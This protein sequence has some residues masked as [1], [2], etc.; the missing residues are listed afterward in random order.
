MALN[1][2]RTTMKLATPL[3]IGTCIQFD[4][5]PWTV[6]GFSGSCVQCRNHQGRT[7]IHDI[8]FLTV[9]EGFKVLNGEELPGPNELVTFP[10]NV[11]EASLRQAETILAHLNEAESGYKSGNRET[12]L[13]EEPRPEYDPEYSTLNQRMEAKSR[14]TGISV[15][16]LWE[17]KA[18]YKHSGI[19]G[20]IDKRQLKSGRNNITDHRVVAAL[21]QVLKEHRDK[22]N[23]TDKRLIALTEQR[24]QDLYPGEKIRFPSSQTMYRILAREHR[25]RAPKSAKRRRNDAN[26]PRT[27]YRHQVSTRPGEFVLIDSTPFDAFALDPV[28]FKWIQLQLTIAIDLFSRSIVGWRFTPVS[29]KAVDAA[30]LLYDIIRPKLM[31]P[32]W[33]QNARWAYLGVPETVVVKL[34]DDEPEDGIAGVPLLH[35]ETIVVDHGKAFISR[36]FKDACSRLGINVQLARTYTPTDKAQVERTFRTIREDFIEA[37]PGY[38]GPDLY[39]RGVNIEDDAF[40]FVDEIDTRFSAWVACE[41]QRRPHEGLFLP[42]VPLLEVSSNEM[43]E[44]GIARAG[45]VYVVASELMYYE[46][47]P[48]EWRTVQHYGVELRGLRYNADILNDYHNVESPWG[49]IHAGKWPIRYDPRDLS[50]VFFFD[51]YSSQWRELPWTHDHGEGRPFNEA[52]LSYAK[53]LLIRRGGNPSDVDELAEAMNGLLDRMCTPSKNDRRERRLAAIN[54]IHS[55][56]V[57]RDQP[58]VKGTKVAPDDEVL[59]VSDGPIEG[60]RN[61]FMEKETR[62][63]GSDEIV[64]LRTVDEAM[65]DDDDDL[66]F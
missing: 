17:M 43:Y 11:S 37:L 45:F 4:G 19:Y 36:A 49:G 26:R 30:L 53:A 5:Q 1:T 57:Q 32:G 25:G 14:Q 2:D 47:L 12:A 33:P 40:Y 55:Q 38:K 48:T 3:T 34:I 28:T 29:T 39:S 51:D 61:I 42:G 7:A 64:P 62:T 46:L 15:R 31:Q 59:L 9:S 6:S 66:G 60:R 10:D 20:L 22:S 65:E 24:V 18:A 23:V 13:P 50:R 21:H 35:P 44:E 63:G 54:A 16:S 58:M 52:S 41:F 27:P 8:A 56:L